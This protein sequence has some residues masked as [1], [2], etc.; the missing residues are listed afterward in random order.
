MNTTTNIENIHNR[1]GTLIDSISKFN[2][3]G[4]EAERLSSDFL[5]AM[6]AVN[7]ELL[8]VRNE[9]IMTEV[10]KNYLFSE[11][12]KKHSGEK[13]TAQKA[14]AITDDNYIAANKEFEELENAIEYL[15]KL[16]EIMQH[17]HVYFRQIAGD[18]R[19]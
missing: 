16:Y 6:A 14:E 17:G 2:C 1:Y 18:R 12:M 8:R 4:V 11:A 10:A 13:V 15:K 3:T 9:K 19:S 7:Y 5:K